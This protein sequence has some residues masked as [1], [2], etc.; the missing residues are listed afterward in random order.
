MK[1]M[2]EWMEGG[3]GRSA[4]RS[5]QFK[6]RRKSAGTHYIGGIHLIM[7][8]SLSNFSV[9]WSRFNLPQNTPNI[10]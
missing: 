1:T 3:C 6:P 10:T 4:S 8:Y 7:F 5:G 9:S 2:G